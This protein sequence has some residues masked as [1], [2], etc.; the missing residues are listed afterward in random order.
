MSHESTLTAL[1]TSMRA[2]VLIAPRTVEVRQVPVPSLT[3]DQV[4]VKITAIG[5]CGSD[6]HFFTEGHIGDLVVDGPL[7]L[8]HE[9]AGR[10][11]AVGSD[12]SDERIGERVS[13]EPQTP[14][15]V[16]TYC[17]IGQYNLCPDVAFYGAP[18]TDGAFSEYAVIPS[19][20]AHAVPDSLSDEAAALIEPL[21]VAI[22]ACRKAGIVAGSKVLVAG[23]GP[24]GVVITQVARAFGATVVLVADP[25]AQRRETVVRFGATRAID[26]LTEDVAALSPAVDIFIDASGA[27]RAIQSGIRAVRSG[28]RVVLVGMGQV[29][30]ELPVALIQMRE[31]ELTGIYR[32]A[33]T[34][35]LA[36]ELASTGV[37][38]LDSLVTGRFGLDDVAEAL[39][40]AG[41]DPAALKSVVLP[42]LTA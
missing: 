33:N 17:K 2:S 25:V 19:D 31:I 34:W 39:L 3:S 12:I 35:P 15:R 24:I 4:L 20:F 11:V 30:L 42:G 21:S 28:G 36:I 9:S 38:D 26:P 41:T 13:I 40:K 29:D 37:V 27:G 6:T 16:C 18:G 14:C 23:A 1:P 22:F 8:G 5:V 7:I 10:I 32:Y